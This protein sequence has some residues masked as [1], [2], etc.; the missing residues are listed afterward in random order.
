MANGKKTIIAILLVAA[1]IE[2]F[3]IVNNPSF[4]PKFLLGVPY[5]P[6]VIYLYLTLIAAVAVGLLWK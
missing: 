6:F 1:I 4:T 3:F 2:A 5:N